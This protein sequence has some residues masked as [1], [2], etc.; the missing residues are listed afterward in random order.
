MITKI[1]NIDIFTNDGEFIKNGYILFD[2]VEITE[3]GQDDSL[4]ECDIEIDGNGKLLMPGFVNC[5]THIYS[6]LSR[7]MPLP[8][9]DPKSFTQ[10][11]E[12]LWWKLDKK[13]LLEDIKMSSYVY[14]IES[15]KAGVTSIFDHH[16]SPYAIENSLDAIFEGTNKVGLRCSSCFEVSDRDGKDR[17]VKEIE[18]NVSQIGKNNEM[19]SVMMGLHASFT[20]SN[21]TLKRISAID[22]VPVHVHVAEGPEDEEMCKDKYGKR[23]IERFE[24]YNLTRKNSIYAHCIRINDDEMEIIR[25]TGGYIAINAQS[26]M[27]N[28]VGISYWP[29]FEKNKIP[30]I[31][32]TDGYGSNLSHDLRFFIL[33]PHQKEKR[34][35]V[36]SPENL[37]ETFF[38]NNYAIAEK[39]FNV[40]LGKI[41]K[42]YRADFLIA[43]YNSPTPIDHENFMNHFFFGVIENL[44]I[45]DV[46]INGKKALSGGT[47]VFVDSSNIY[48]RSRKISKELWERIRGK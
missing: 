33:S 36:S 21:K 5:H 19:R 3:I 48:D 14:A 9:F 26:N 44:N 15:L 42:G 23:I 41:K 29:K 45:K 16:S 38:K 25:K 46:Y 2:E 35:A 1:K 6:T 32:G 30:V 47:P 24:K 31:V 43:D 39:I 17:A 13:L 8:R 10:I 34:V 12:Q 20:L 27:N 7:G 28:G 11:L 4:S 22:G 40:R 37:R 18:E